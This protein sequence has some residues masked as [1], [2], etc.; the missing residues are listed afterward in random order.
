MS[1]G[2]HIRLA[3]EAD[4]QALLALLDST[5]QQGL[6]TLNFERHPDFFH[7]SAVVGQQSYVVVAE[8]RETGALD[9]VSSLSFRE[10]FINGRPRRIGYAN[11]LRISNHYRGSRLL[12][13]LFRHSRQFQPDDEFSQTVILDENAASLGTVASG[14]GGM[15]HYYP[16]GRLNTYLIATAYD[17]SSRPQY[18][19]SQARP[20]DVPAM[21]AF[22]DQQAPK[23]Q[24][25]PL[26]HFD[27]VGSDDPY[28]RDIR[29]KDFFL[30]R[31]RGQV[32]GI[33]GL[34][35]Q[36]AFKQTKV[37]DYPR[38]MHWLRPLYNLWCSVAGGFPLPARGQVAE[39]V[40]LHSV[41][42]RDEEPAILNSLL[43]AA[44]RELRQRGEATMVLALS[45]GDPLEPALKGFVRRR[46]G[47]QHFLVSHGPDCRAQLNAGLPLY[48][49]VAR[50]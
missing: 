45:Q 31:E 30:V 11:D 36:K 26:Y 10:V 43:Q 46:M 39:Y 14:R 44:R 3:T 50:L 5:P 47:S 34:W 21:Q 2:H 29:L 25:Y 16:Y 6:V 42:V 23:R 24:F 18:G 38:W 40:N 32:I 19:V 22:F 1:S 27:R 7:G 41:L 8:S 48:L 33:C 28:Y 4:N 49:E 37:V 12:L 20:N 9:G 35:K 17:F 15:P 13:K